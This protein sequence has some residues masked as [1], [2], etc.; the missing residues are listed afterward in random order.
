MVRVLTVSR[1]YAS[2]GGQLAR[3]LAERLG[4]RLVD[5][6]LI[7]RIAQAARVEPQVAAQFDERVDPWFHRLSRAALWR[8][9]FEGVAAVTDEDFFDAARMAGLARRL[10]EEA[11]ALGDCVIV[12]RGAQCVLG[13]RP[14]VFHLF[15]YA[16]RAERLK[17]A[18]RRRVADPEIALDERDRARF[19]YIRE[20]YQEDSLNPHLYHLMINSALG[21]ATAISTILTAMGREGGAPGSL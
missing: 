4:W 14:E 17:E 8:G 13:G 16:P 21:E 20:Y 11:A 18:R 3:R 7:Q 12:G 15:V 5:R 19:S 1:E 2:G 6:E 10:I 9:A